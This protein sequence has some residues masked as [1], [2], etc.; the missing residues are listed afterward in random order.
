M[1]DDRIVQVDDLER[2]P[3]GCRRDTGTLV[4]PGR[5]MELVADAAGASSAYTQVCHRHVILS[6][7]G[8]CGCARGAGWSREAGRG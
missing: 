6:D 2:G 8:I 3:R 1:A 4:V 5:R 7:R